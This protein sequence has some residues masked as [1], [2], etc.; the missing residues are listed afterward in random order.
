VEDVLAE[1]EVPA[2]IRPAS[3]TGLRAP[4]P[5]P[6]LDPDA[7]AVLAALDPSEPLNTDAHVTATGL[8]AARLSSALVRLE[9][10]GLVTALPGALFV[11][12]AGRA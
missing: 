9:L 5:P 2:L 11:R 8:T 3:R 7:A 4:V 12:L 1:L 6:E 10:E